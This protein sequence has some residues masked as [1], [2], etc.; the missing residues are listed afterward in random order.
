MA[1]AQLEGKGWKMDIDTEGEDDQSR[2]DDESLLRLRPP[3]GPPHFSG[4]A[5]SS[6][7]YTDSAELQVVGAPT[8]G[9]VRAHRPH[10]AG[11]ARLHA[12]GSGLKRGPRLLRA[13]RG[14]AGRLAQWAV[15]GRLGARR[16]SARRVEDHIAR[17]TSK[18]NQGGRSSIWKRYFE[19]RRAHLDRLPTTNIRF[20][21]IGGWNRRP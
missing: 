7:T 9:G 6:T 15:R 3:S 4:P 11:K 13:V 8:R 14:R 1:R 18:I 12:F 5:S 10:G 21:L 19:L 17:C 2:A 16:W 20:P